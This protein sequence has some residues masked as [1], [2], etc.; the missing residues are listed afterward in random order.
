M[1]C[2]C[3]ISGVETTSN[4]MLYS[5]DVIKLKRIQIHQTRYQWLTAPFMT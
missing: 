3:K 2:I 1:N 5:N 4:I